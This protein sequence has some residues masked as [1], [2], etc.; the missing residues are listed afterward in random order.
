MHRTRKGRPLRAASRHAMER[1]DLAPS[2]RIGTAYLASF[3]LPLV[4]FE[5]GFFLSGMGITLKRR[6]PRVG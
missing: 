4:F 2:V 6:P 1:T 5:L 3:S